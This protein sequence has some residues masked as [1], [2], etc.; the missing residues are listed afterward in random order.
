MAR[1]PFTLARRL[2]CKE[3]FQSLATAVRLITHYGRPDQGIA[4]HR[5][6][7]IEKRVRRGERREAPE[8]RFQAPSKTKPKNIF[9][10]VESTK[11]KLQKHQFL[12][13]FGDE[14]VFRPLYGC[15][16]VDVKI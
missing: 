12:P 1:A 5:T 2:R 13:C 15:G 7:E 11:I 14:Q 10:Q 3:G 8:N 16:S 4:L 9:A 6:S